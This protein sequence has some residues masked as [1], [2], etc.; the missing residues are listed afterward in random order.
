M[1]EGGLLE[2]HF[3]EIEEPPKTPE[4]KFTARRSDSHLPNS[5]ENHSSVVMENME[6]V[7]FY[8]SSSNSRWR[9]QIYKINSRTLILALRSF[10]N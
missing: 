3:Y 4:I 1:R 7:Q 6:N 10:C 5:E 8:L 9:T 2:S